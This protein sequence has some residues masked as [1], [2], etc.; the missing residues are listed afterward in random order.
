MSGLVVCAGCKRHVRDA[1][2]TCPFCRAPVAILKALPRA[3][4][5]RMATAAAVATSVAATGCS[6]TTGTRSAPFY[7]G[8]GVVTDDADTSADSNDDSPNAVPF[9]GSPFTDGSM[10]TLPD[11][12]T[13]DAPMADQASDALV[14]DAGS[15]GEQ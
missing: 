13:S 10:V 4:F 6:S 14:G 15:D 2:S 7:G 9:Y 11:A 5:R 12:P 1:E 3:P 8:P